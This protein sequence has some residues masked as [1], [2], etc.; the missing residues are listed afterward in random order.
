VPEAM[1][2]LSYPVF[3]HPRNAGRKDLGCPFGCRE[4]HRRQNAIRRSTEYYQSPEGK[5]KKKHLNAA[6][7]EQNRLT[8]PSLDEKGNDDGVCKIDDAM[9][10]H[11]QL[12]ASLVEG[13][14]VGL[15]E[16]F[17]MLERVLRQHSID[18]VVKLPYGALCHQK[19]PP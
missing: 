2:A 1:Q 19:N 8:E 6:R 10:S 5:E 18:S 7:S 14:W 16:I 12:V 3:T 11:I 9:V 15:A 13:R 4:A 17:T